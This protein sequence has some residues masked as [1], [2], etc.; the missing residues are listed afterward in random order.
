MQNSIG[1]IIRKK[2]KELCM[3]QQ[4]LAELVG[5]DVYY[6]S[7]IENGRRNPGSKFLIALSNSLSLPIDS[8]LGLESNVVLHEQVSSLELKL[9]QLDTQDREMLLKIFN[10]LID[11]LT[12]N[13]ITTK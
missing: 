6:I 12:S 13:N 5:T 7:K 9:Q 11:R 8:L 2:R 3:T 4:D 1:E 10:Q